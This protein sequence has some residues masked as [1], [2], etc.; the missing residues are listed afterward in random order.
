M[1]DRLSSVRF[2]FNTLSDVLNGGGNV[3][4]A[5]LLGRKIA[6]KPRPVQFPGESGERRRRR[7]V[8][9]ASAPLPHAP[10]GGPLLEINFSYLELAGCRKNRLRSVL[11]I[12]ASVKDLMRTVSLSLILMSRTKFDC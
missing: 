5:V 1:N 6:L 8:E 9:P 3:G 10:C 4:V 11:T 12:A 7:A 2:D